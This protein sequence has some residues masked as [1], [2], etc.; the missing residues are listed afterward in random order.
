MFKIKIDLYILSIVATAAISSLFPATGN[1]SDYLN[2]I[3]NIAIAFLFF[4]YGARLS[5]QQ[6]LNGLK[7]WKLHSIIAFCTF[8]LFPIL[9]MFFQVLV[10]KILPLKLYNGI[11]FLSILP[12]T[13]QSSIAF[14]SIARGNIAGAICAATLSSVIGV[15]ATPLLIVFL[16]DNDS[17]FTLEIFLN[18]MF[19]IVLPFILGQL[20]QPRINLFIHRN[21]F[22]L[23]YLDRGSILLLIYS[24][25]SEAAELNIWKQFSFYKIIILIFILIVLL[26]FVMIISL[27]LSRFYGFSREDEI[28]IFFCGSKKSLTVGLPMAS[29]MFPAS[30]VAIIVIPLML[31]HQIQLIVC[32]IIAQRYSKT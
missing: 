5:P 7:N 29:I 4:F 30:Q 11:L 20:L 32:A 14:T 18:L 12:S 13:V 16:M 3:I 27:G 6:I 17:A 10:P 23:N 31:F 26:A 21:K 1:I 22:L 19:Q 8:I 9:G 28:V 15:F 24:A 25:F 2:F